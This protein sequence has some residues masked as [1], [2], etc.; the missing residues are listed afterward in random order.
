MISHLVDARVAA[1]VVVFAALLPQVSQAKDFIAAEKTGSA[2]Q[3]AIDEAS[4]AVGPSFEK[5]V[6]LVE[7]Y[8]RKGGIRLR[9]NHPY[10]LLP[11]P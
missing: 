4:A 2:V 9:L 3:R 5:T 10:C 1:L 6:V 11:N 8:F 7:T